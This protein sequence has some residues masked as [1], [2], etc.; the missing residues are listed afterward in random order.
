MGRRRVTYSAPPAGDVLRSVVIIKVAAV[1]AKVKEKNF[2]A[3]FKLINRI[4][5][6]IGRI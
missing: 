5:N 1:L 2:G 6:N 4:N 3:P